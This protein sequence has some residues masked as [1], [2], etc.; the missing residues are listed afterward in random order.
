MILTCKQSTEV[1]QTVASSAVTPAT[2]NHRYCTVS[3]FR[4]NVISLDNSTGT[5]SSAIVG[6]FR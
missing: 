3:R 6:L 2:T 4:N 1:K 5:V